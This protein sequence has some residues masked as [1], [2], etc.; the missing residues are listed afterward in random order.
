MVFT[1]CFYSEPDA[2]VILHHVEVR[3]IPVLHVDLHQIHYSEQ[4]DVIVERSN[5]DIELIDSEIES[6]SYIE[7]V[8]RIV[9]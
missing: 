4:S 9:K 6:L 1:V 7:K 8:V 2:C 3:I 5:H